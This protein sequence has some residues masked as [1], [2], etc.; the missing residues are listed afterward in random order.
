MSYKGSEW[1]NKKDWKRLSVKIPSEDYEALKQ[2]AKDELKTVH[3]KI[4]ELIK[5]EVS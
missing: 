5:I 3:K 1:K 2:K 4:V